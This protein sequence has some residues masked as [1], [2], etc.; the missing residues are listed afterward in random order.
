MMCAV[1]NFNTILFSLVT[2]GSLFAQ[3]PRNICSTTQK[4]FTQ[5]PSF[6]EGEA[7]DFILESQQTTVGL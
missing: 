7:E 6:L 5:S 3:N 4:C 2:I 1:S